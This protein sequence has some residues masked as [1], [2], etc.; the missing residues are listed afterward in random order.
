MKYIILFIVFNSILS[1]RFYGQNRG[2]ETYI[3]GE[4]K[5]SQETIKCYMTLQD[6]YPSMIKYKLN[7]DDKKPLKIKASEVVELKRGSSKFKRLNYKGSSMLLKVIVNGKI[8][9]YESRIQRTMMT[10]G[11]NGW[12]STPVGFDEPLYYIEKDNDVYKINKNK[13]KSKLKTIL[14][15]VDEIDK[16]IDELRYR[17]LQ[18][19][20][21]QIIKKYNQ[22]NRQ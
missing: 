3:G 9:L 17:D 6:F 20:L 5:T 19:K 21:P 12:Q 10:N 13:F 15:G 4:I 22:L 18:F 1:T 2:T 11:V 7:K 8:S 14:S 16:Q